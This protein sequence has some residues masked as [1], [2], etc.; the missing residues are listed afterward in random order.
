MAELLF[1]LWIMK[2]LCDVIVTTSMLKKC[3]CCNMFIETV[4]KIYK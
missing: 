2:S 1:L 3:V 4:T